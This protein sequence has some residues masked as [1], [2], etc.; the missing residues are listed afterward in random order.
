MASSPND[1]SGSEDG[2]VERWTD[3]S[4]GIVLIVICVQWS[5]GT[6]ITMFDFPC[7]GEYSSLL[8]CLGSCCH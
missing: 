3:L 4:L 6:R 1:N 5:I 8:K 7:R 2:E